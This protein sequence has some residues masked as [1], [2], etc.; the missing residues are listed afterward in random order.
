MS[1]KK[2]GKDPVKVRAGSM[3]GRPSYPA[4]QRLERAAQVWMKPGDIEKIKAAAERRGVPTGSEIRDML[5]VLLEE[6]GPM[7]RGVL[8]AIRVELGLDEMATGGGRE[9]TR[10]RPPRPGVVPSDGR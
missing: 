7:T 10:Q 9:R 6:P 5:L 1:G 2:S 8:T 3:G 4:D